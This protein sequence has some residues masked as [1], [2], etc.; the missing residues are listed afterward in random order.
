MQSVGDSESLSFIEE[1]KTFLLIYAVL[2]NG[3]KSQ[4]GVL[5]IKMLAPLHDAW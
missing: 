1:K 5:H 4:V 3:I 2:V